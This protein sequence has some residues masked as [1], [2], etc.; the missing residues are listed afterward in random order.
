M[1]ITDI[2]GLKHNGLEAIEAKLNGILIWKSENYVDIEFTTSLFPTSWTEVTTGTNYTATDDYG[3]WEISC[4]GYDFS[5]VNAFDGDEGTRWRSPSLSSNT[6]NATVEINCPV[7]IKPQ[8]IYGRFG[9]IGSNSVIQGYN[10]GTGSWET[11]CEI[12]RGQSSQLFVDEDITTENYYYKFRALTYRYSSSYKQPSVYE[13]Q[14]T[15][16][17][18]RL[19]AGSIDTTQKDF[20]VCPFPTSWTKGA[21]YSNYSSTNEYGEWNISSTGGFISGHYVQS[22]F[23]NKTSTW[24]S[25]WQSGTLSSDSASASVEIECPVYIKP[26]S[27]FIFHQYNS[28]TSSVQAYNEDTATWETLYNLKE[29]SG[30]E[31]VTITT[32]KFYKKFRVVGYRYSYQNTFVQIHEFQITSGTMKGA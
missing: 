32:D 11:L 3:T 18:I 16:G 27:I 26:T 20:S 19:K 10:E 28:A 6:A 31:T 23:D 25:Y 21:N 13:F 5:V 12:P 17:T 2:L 9:I 14:I 24:T 4:S 8:H 7:K 1:K 15:S 30:K 22:A 29:N